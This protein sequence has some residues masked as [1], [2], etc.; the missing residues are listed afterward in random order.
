MA[1]LSVWKFNDPNGAENAAEILE[2]L[3]KQELVKIH[4]AATVTWPEGKKRPKTR[5]LHHLAG[6]GA[7][8]VSFWGLLFGLLFFVPLLGLAV[9]AAV[10]GLSGSLADVGIDDDF[11]NGVREEVQPGTSAL[12][13]LTS[14]AVLDKVRDAFAGTKPELIHTNLSDDEEARLRDLFAEE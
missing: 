14:D 3:Q 7:L 2:G 10:G 4:D 1:T 12:F 6:L 11:I 13:V 9:G 8:S 5:Q